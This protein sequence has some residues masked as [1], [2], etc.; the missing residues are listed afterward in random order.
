MS[1]PSQHTV[2]TPATD[3]GQ[4]LNESPLALLSQTGSAS[5]STIA[6]EGAR[7]ACRKLEIARSGSRPLAWACGGIVEG[8]E[9]TNGAVESIGINHLRS[10]VR[11]NTATVD[12]DRTGSERLRRSGGCKL[13]VTS[14][15]VRGRH[16]PAS[17]GVPPCGYH[18]TPLPSAAETTL[19]GGLIGP[20]PTSNRRPWPNHRRA[21][22]LVD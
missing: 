5:P 9:V 12:L 15:S 22:G 1:A 20:S 10:T 14:A 17:A 4:S 21:F 19:A 7:L 3:P 11:I 8:R 6:N 2:S 16:T 18:G 13:L